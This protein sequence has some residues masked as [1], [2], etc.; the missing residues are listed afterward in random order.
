MNDVR[1]NCNFC[2]LIN[3]F[4]Y[5]IFTMVAGNPAKVKAFASSMPNSPYFDQPL[6]I[7][8]GGIYSL[9]LTGSNSAPEAVFVKDNIPPFPVA[10][11]INVRFVNLS[12]NAG[13]LNVTLAA[14]PTVNIFT[15]VE[16]KQVANFVNLPFPLTVPSGTNV[17]QIRN[18]AGTL[19]LS[20]TLPANGT[21]SITSSRHRNITLV[22]RGKIGG[23]GSDAL[24]ILGVPHY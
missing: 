24:A 18:T 6:E 20:Y 15:N 12:T 4:N 2:T 14:A 23:T 3:N 11:V 21:V 7:V 8:P 1:N 5:K 13:T 9:F 10:D 22:L 19:L 16:Y 17:F